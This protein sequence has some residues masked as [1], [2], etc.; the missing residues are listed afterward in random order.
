M[1]MI[2]MQFLDVS[3]AHFHALA[4]RLMFIK[5]PP[6]DEAPG[7]V[8]RLLRSLY[9]TRDAAANWEAEWLRIFRD[10]KYSAGLFNPC[11][12]FQPERK[13]ITFV[14]GDD[15]VTVGEERH[16]QWL[17]DELAKS[18]IIKELAR[19]GTGS[20]DDKMVVCLN[21]LLNL[22]HVFWIVGN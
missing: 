20:S 2:K 21:R 16:V 19:L 18:L 10:I 7:M 8:G 1:L 11:V 9:G 5:L 13:L 12:L 17:K 14:Y 4:T 3:R 22:V 6:G 15:F